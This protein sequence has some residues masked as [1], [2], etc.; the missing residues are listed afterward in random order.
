[1]TSRECS[2]KAAAEWLA[3]PVTEMLHD[4]LKWLLEQRKAALSESFLS[5]RDD[6]SRSRAEYQG[7]AQLFADLFGD[8]PAEL[9][10][11]ITATLKRM[12]DEQ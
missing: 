8:N 11:D 5:G 4:A 3:H 9:A 6:L 2:E 10:A 1:M 7:S 12:E